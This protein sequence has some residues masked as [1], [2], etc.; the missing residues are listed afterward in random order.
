[1]EKR[2]EILKELDKGNNI[3]IINYCFKEIAEKCWW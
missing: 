2:E 1:M 3:F